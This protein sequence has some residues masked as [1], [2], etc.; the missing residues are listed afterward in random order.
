[1]PDFPTIEDTRK[2]IRD[3]QVSADYTHRLIAQSR[4]ALSESLELIAR[5]NQLL[6]GTGRIPSPAASFEYSDDDRTGRSSR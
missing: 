5:A 4:E 2:F 6:A 3:L 1:M